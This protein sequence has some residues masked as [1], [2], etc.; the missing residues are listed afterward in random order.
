MPSFAE[1]QRRVSVNVDHSPMRGHPEERSDEGS[2]FI[3]CDLGTA[4]VLSD[5]W[6]AAAVPYA[7]AMH[8]RLCHVYIVASRSR[9]LYVGVTAN[10]LRRVFEHRHGK[11]EGFTARYQCTRLVWCEA[12]VDI[13]RAIVREKEVKGWSRAKKFALVEAEN[14]AWEDLSLSLFGWK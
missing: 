4:Q 9:V 13:G 11:G 3:F 6:E 2:A 7:I 10:L 8:D 1:M 12:H 5:W 14:R